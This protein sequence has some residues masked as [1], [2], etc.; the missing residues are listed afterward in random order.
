KAVAVIGETLPTFSKGFKFAAE[1]MWFEEVILPQAYG[2]AGKGV[3]VATGTRA[4]GQF[5]EETLPDW[6]E[7]YHGRIASAEFAKAYLARRNIDVKSINNY[8]S[9]EYGSVDVI[10]TSEPQKVIDTF[11]LQSGIDSGEIRIIENADGL[12]LRQPGKAALAITTQDNF[13]ESNGLIRTNAPVNYET[14]TGIVSIARTD[15]NDV[16]LIANSLRNTQGITNIVVDQTNGVVTAEQNK[17]QFALATSNSRIDTG[18]RINSVEIKGEVN[19]NI[20]RQNKEDIATIGH[21]RTVL[22]GT[23]ANL[24]SRE[25]VYLSGGEVWQS[26]SMNNLDARQAAEVLSKDNNFD[27]VSVSNNRVFARDLLT[28]AQII[29]ETG[30]SIKP[31]AQIEIAGT[32]LQ[33]LKVETPAIVQE[34]I[35]IS[36]DNE[37]IRKVE[38]S[39]SA[40]AFESALQQQDNVQIIKEA[41][42]DDDIIIYSQNGQKVIVVQQGITPQI[43]DGKRVTT[44]E[45]SIADSIKENIDVTTSE[46][47]RAVT[48]QKAVEDKGLVGKIVDKITGREVPQE[49]INEIASE[50]AFDIKTKEP[51]EVLPKL[52]EAGLIDEDLNPRVDNP[53]IKGYVAS[54]KESIDSKDLSS[55]SLVKIMDDLIKTRHDPA[56][57][58]FAHGTNAKSLEGILSLGG[59]IL[60]QDE[61]MKNGGEIVTGENAG[62]S[63]TGDKISTVGGSHVSWA[64]EYSELASGSYAITPNSIDAKIRDQEEFI[65]TIISNDAIIRNG[66][67]SIDRENERLTH[68]KKL[69]EKFSKMSDSEKLD[70][71]KLSSIPIV[72]LGK[73]QAVNIPSQDGYETQISGEILMNYLRTEIIAVPSESIPF[74]AEMVKK[75][76]QEIAIIPL[77]NLNR[78]SNVAWNLIHYE[79]LIFSAVSASIPSKDEISSLSKGNIK[80]PILYKFQSEDKKEISIV[81]DIQD[82]WEQIREIFEDAMSSVRPIQVPPEIKSAVD[83]FI[84]FNPELGLIR[85]GDGFIDYQTMYE[86]YKSA[87]DNLESFEQSLALLDP[88]GT[89]KALD[90]ET[91]RVLSSALSKGNLKQKEILAAINQLSEIKDIDVRIYIA[92]GLEAGRIKIEDIP[93]ILYDIE[94]YLGR[95]TGAS[96]DEFVRIHNVEAIPE[97]SE[98]SFFGD[99]LDSAQLKSFLVQTFETRDNVKISNQQ[100]AKEIA[101]QIETNFHGILAGTYKLRIGGLEYTIKA[102]NKPVKRSTEANA[103]YNINAEENI[104]TITTSTPS[105]VIELLR[106]DK[107][108]AAGI[109]GGQNVEDVAETYLVGIQVGH[110]LGSAIYAIQREMFQDR[111]IS[112]SDINNYESSEAHTFGAMVA[113]EM[114]KGTKIESS[115]RKALQDK[116]KEKQSLST[117]SQAVEYY[118]LLDLPSFARG[119]IEAN[120]LLDIV[121]SYIVDTKDVVAL[122]LDEEW[123]GT[124]Y[125]KRWINEIKSKI[126]D[127][128]N[129]G[130]TDEEIIN[131][132]LTEGRIEEN[133]LD[134]YVEQ[135]QNTEKREKELRKELDKRGRLHNAI[136]SFFGS[137]YKWRVIRI[138]KGIKS[139]EGV[140]KAVLYAS[141]YISNR[142][143]I[144]SMTPEQMVRL[145]E[146]LSRLGTRTEKIQELL[147]EEMVSQARPSVSQ[148][149]PMILAIW[150]DYSKEQYYRK[151]DYMQRIRK[152]LLQTSQLLSNKESENLQEYLLLQIEK[153]QSYFDFY[154]LQNLFGDFTYN[155]LLIKKI[156]DKNTENR[157][158]YVNNLVVT[159]KGIDTL[160]FLERLISNTD[161]DILV[162]I[163]AVD[164][165]FSHLQYQSGKEQDKEKHFKPA[166]GVIKEGLFSDNPEVVKAT[167]KLFGLDYTVSH[168]R[169]KLFKDDFR[170]FFENNP[171]ILSRLLDKDNIGNALLISDIIKTYKLDNQGAKL[172]DVLVTSTD[173]GVWQR[174]KLVESLVTLDNKAVAE[175]VLQNLDKIGSREL[176]GIVS[177]FR[178]QR[179][180]DKILELEGSEQFNKNF[181]NYVA[182]LGSVSYTDENLRKK[183]EEFALRYINVKT[184]R[185]DK[186][187]LARL[188]AK[189]SR[190]PDI[191]LNSIS[192][193]DLSLFYGDEWKTNAEIVDN[194]ISFN[195]PRFDTLLIEGDGFNYYGNIDAN[196]ESNKRIFDYFASRDTGNEMA[197]L[198]Q[199]LERIEGMPSYQR[200][201][202]VK[203]YGIKRTAD[204]IKQNPNKRYEWE[205]YLIGRTGAGDSNRNGVILRILS[206]AKS[207]SFIEAFSRMDIQSM[208]FDSFYALGLSASSADIEFIMQALI[209]NGADQQIGYVLEGIASRQDKFSGNDRDIENIFDLALGRLAGRQRYYYESE[210]EK[211]IKSL[212]AN[213]IYEA[214]VKNALV[215]GFVDGKEGEALKKLI[216]EIKDPDFTRQLYENLKEKL[217][218]EKFASSYQWEIL[219]ERISPIF[220]QVI[221]DYERANRGDSTN[222]AFNSFVDGLIRSISDPD[223]ESKVLEIIKTEPRESAKR[224][225]L[226]DRLS[227]IGKEGSFDFLVDNFEQIHYSHS[228]LKEISSRIPREHVEQ[229]LP[230]IIE[231]ASQF[232]DDLATVLN[233]APQISFELLQDDIKNNARSDSEEMNGR[234]YRDYRYISALEGLSHEQYSSI[235]DLLLSDLQIEQDKGG[236]QFLLSSVTNLIKKVDK[237][238]REKLI[239]V[240]LEELRKFN[241]DKDKLLEQIKK[242]AGEDS[243]LVKSIESGKIF[244]EYSYGSSGTRKLAQNYAHQ[245][246]PLE[247]I[248]DLILAYSETGSQ[249]S[250]ELLGEFVKSLKFVSSDSNRIARIF[251]LKNKDMLR[252]LEKIAS[253]DTVNEYEFKKFVGIIRT[254]LTENKETADAAFKT[255][256]KLVTETEL[257]EQRAVVLTEAIGTF[258]SQNSVKV[259]END[260]NKLLNLWKSPLVTDKLKAS[261]RSAL[262]RT[263]FQTN[264][265]IDDS[266]IENIFWK[267]L[268]LPEPEVKV[269]ETYNSIGG[270]A[271]N[272]YLS[273][274]VGSSQFRQF[275]LDKRFDDFLRSTGDEENRDRIQAAKSKILQVLTSSPHLRDAVLVQ[276][277]DGKY[278]VVENMLAM[279]NY[280]LEA[281]LG[282][283]LIYREG[284]EGI[285]NNKNV[286]EQLEA[287]NVNIIRN[288]EDLIILYD[289][290]NKQRRRI[291]E[292]SLESALFGQ[293]ATPEVINFAYNYGENPQVT[294]LA[295]EHGQ[296]NNYLISKIKEALKI[297]RRRTIEGLENRL[298]GTQLVQFA[299]G[300]T[301]LENILQQRQ[302]RIA[303]SNR[304]KAEIEA[305]INQNPE[306]I[307]GTGFYGALTTARKNGLTISLVSGASRNPLMNVIF[308]QNQPLTGDIDVRVLS[309]KLD[310]NELQNCPQCNQQHVQR[311]IEYMRNNKIRTIVLPAFDVG[312]E[313]KIKRFD[314]VGVE[315]LKLARVKAVIN[316][317]L[318]DIFKEELIQFYEDSQ[319]SD[320]KIK[321]HLS[322]TSDP[323]SITF[324]NLEFLLTEFTTQRLPGGV[325]LRGDASAVT[326]GD[327]TINTIEIRFD[328]KGKL[329]IDD[330]EQGLLDLRDRIGRLSYGSLAVYGKRRPVNIGVNAINEIAVADYLRFVRTRWQFGF[331]LD[332]E[333]DE[334]LKAGMNYYAQKDESTK[335]ALQDKI[336]RNA[337]KILKN[338]PED[339]TSDEKQLLIREIGS[340]FERAGSL[341]YLSNKIREADPVFRQKNAVFQLLEPED[342]VQMLKGQSFA[343]KNLV[344]HGTPKKKVQYIEVDTYTN[345]E[346][347]IDSGGLKPGWINAYGRGVYMSHDSETPFQYGVAGGGMIVFKKEFIGNLIQKLKENPQVDEAG[348]G[349]VSRDPN[350]QGDNSP[351][352]VVGIPLLSL[353]H[354]EAVFLTGDN[355]A[356]AQALFRNKL[357]E[358]KLTVINE[359][360]DL[361]EESLEKLIEEEQSKYQEKL[362]G[363]GRRFEDVFKNINEIDTI[364]PTQTN[365]IELIK[366]F[367]NDPKKLEEYKEYAK[368]LGKSDAEIEN[369]VKAGTEEVGLNKNSN[370]GTKLDGNVELNQWLFDSIKSK[371]VALAA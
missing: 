69:K 15:S 20:I 363:P 323:A 190:N 267:E 205:S 14:S 104:I 25:V 17:V 239:A 46:T 136:R 369:A 31:S 326:R 349:L 254:S 221:E 47:L 144:D 50:I 271:R 235:V 362:L 40:L 312:L 204:K 98:V 243:D 117:L 230:M 37:P 310:I 6:A 315:N 314:R 234:R 105:D 337:D 176:W 280:G 320:E 195:D 217:G 75:S 36:E 132:L 11:G 7:M 99:G 59:N 325:D 86:K 143:L 76:G 368:V 113:K 186:W 121:I 65:Q 115:T 63:N 303:E 214:N 60:P 108:F 296:L 229:K 97:F 51:T 150:S 273:L 84:A 225:L 78:M 16:M 219:G 354:A 2:T 116:I 322:R 168:E 110:E 343:M 197:I 191:V 198:L 350:I 307:F 178:D 96:I 72:V 107:N 163:A 246:E 237:D 260:L 201:N 275:V 138:A 301:T 62:A 26:L 13:A 128:R 189:V 45:Q 216:T 145:H 58:Y 123:P 74:V 161:E 258:A 188:I 118:L 274:L 141:A 41:I 277:P 346:N 4:V 241:S 57:D 334:I 291:I 157:V 159:T 276:R 127:L 64:I 285:I 298:S 101:Q 156:E 317:P 220:D 203:D 93:T 80:S 70:W 233:L 345:I 202:E 236:R 208:S 340:I 179:F 175:W 167:L 266:I 174:N 210:I 142:F 85:K 332:R 79:G 284:T 330:P 137:F 44:I 164:K 90:R 223:V 290:A 5:A 135:P 328:N 24:R 321:E 213:P 261:L 10:Q 42:S 184:D 356:R 77:E 183:A 177:R 308:G 352:Y 35:L 248:H 355:Y 155:N 61:V 344:V 309:V 120:N 165:L 32:R 103:L 287:K 262:A 71:E 170:A 192:N 364:M 54:V 111:R 288:I 302:A 23:N 256:L 56:I 224:Q 162:R 316:S 265:D 370:S 347:I 207:S 318:G 199:I 119:H 81:A 218:P 240:G 169:T 112:L 125:T 94:Q 29:I 209:K 91:I 327:T 270:Y 151:H 109:G 283:A 194:I 124:P 154:F 338:L 353:E 304:Y 131:E 180:V 95:D 89:T 339:L 139:E 21:V 106:Q 292:K 193:L 34:E 371:T 282:L 27:V 289:K 134:R 67:I 294:E 299:K 329:V 160:N 185:N 313:E 281:E 172:Y 311:V 30:A 1:E 324:Q 18:G 114:F 365:I 279:L 336:T 92:Q 331:N 247:R 268:G 226:L 129:K 252:Y 359:N 360:K 3:D 367:V 158:A 335:G 358:I 88:Y 66:L 259:D 305:K 68:L 351:H 130:L 173:I 33:V 149:A 341:Q 19:D 87:I 215:K 28:N 100:K 242:E 9:P 133:K 249:L 196:V 231:K 82:D 348:Q 232:T 8:F 319:I 153:S 22:A 39:G 244:E 122:N 148:G 147:E 250:D 152:V 357:D 166:L 295:F 200:N 49:K 269:R 43:V 333:S 55:Q 272:N 342:R 181:A 48:Q 83:R 257:S 211:S 146:E 73:E 238:S 264:V 263:V 278:Q 53:A 227:S 297:N 222:Y 228:M 52:I 361:D 255:T 187:N 102:E 286:R 126:S 12:I 300:E 38:I 251:Y 306:K 171:E 253:S 182:A 212:L 206:E 366:K 293:L 245:N 140:N